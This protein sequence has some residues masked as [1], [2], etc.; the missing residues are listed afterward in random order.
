MAF[1]WKETWNPN[2]QMNSKFLFGTYADICIMNT[3]VVLEMR[4]EM[5][6][7]KWKHEKIQQNKNYGIFCYLRSEV[8]LDHSA[9]REWFHSMTREQENE[10]MR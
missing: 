4:I 2:L 5:C 6:L 10:T 9:T 1:K 8:H 3:Q 7:G